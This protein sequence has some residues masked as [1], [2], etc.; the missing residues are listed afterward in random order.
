MVGDAQ[1]RPQTRDVEIHQERTRGLLALIGLLIFLAT[2]I[3]A[4][5]L[6]GGDHWANA[7]ELLQIFLP[8]ETALIGTVGGFY[9]G[10]K[11]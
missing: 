11:K 6:A 2:L 5:F 4:F 1:P 7:K 3:G 9:F 10:A 8:A